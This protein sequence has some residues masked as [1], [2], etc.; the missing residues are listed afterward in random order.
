MRIYKYVRWMINSF[1]P[2]SSH[3][4]ITYK[5]VLLVAKPL[6]IPAG[7]ERAL[8]HVQLHPPSRPG[9]W[10]PGKDSNTR[11][12]ETAGILRKGLFFLNPPAPCLLGKHAM[13]ESSGP[14]LTGAEAEL[15]PS[16]RQTNKPYRRC[17]DV[18]QMVSGRWSH[19]WL[20]DAHYF[21]PIL[22]RNLHASWAISPPVV[23]LLSA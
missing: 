10:E 7:P 12:E 14:T 20:G 8:A 13:R 4:S 23:R 18:A 15:E 3:V 6:P 16:S 22:S 2:A 5:L 21:S 11:Q 19:V 17:C 1:Y 9:S